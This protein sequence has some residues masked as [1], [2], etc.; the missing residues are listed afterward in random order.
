MSN[1]N[2]LSDND[3]KT[4]KISKPF[5]V[6]LACVFGFLSTIPPLF[7]S[8]TEVAYMEGKWYVNFLLIISFLTW[9]SLIAIWKMKKLGIFAYIIFTITLY[10][11]LFR[12]SIL[13]QYV[14]TIISII[15]VVLLMFS[16]RKTK[17]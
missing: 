17:W 11:V 16:L 1:M 4:E 14:G 5:I 3:S 6:T 2:T 9:L 7:L 12:F 13:S 8:T 10:I 15:T